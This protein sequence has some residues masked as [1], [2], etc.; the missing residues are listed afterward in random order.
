MK[1]EIIYNEHTEGIIKDIE[2]TFFSQKHNSQVQI[3]AEDI[4]HIFGYI[5]KLEKENKKYKNDEKYFTELGFTNIEQLATMYKH[6][7]S[8]I[9]NGES[10]WN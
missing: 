7:K 5:K 1:Y 8:K 2:E 3:D 9:D 6:I 10:N 4:C